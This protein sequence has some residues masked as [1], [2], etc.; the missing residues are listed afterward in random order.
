ME[1]L[2]KKKPMKP[3]NLNAENIITRMYDTWQTYMIDKNMSMPV[4]SNLYVQFMHKRSTLRWVRAIDFNMR[5]TH[6]KS[7]MEL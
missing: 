6:I 3:I 2:E 7:L 4:Y 1:Q 5:I